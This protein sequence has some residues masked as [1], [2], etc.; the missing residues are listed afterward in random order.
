MKK[1]IRNFDFLESLKPGSNELKVK[2]IETLEHC[3]QLIVVI[4]M[5]NRETGHFKMDLH[6]VF[7][8]RDKK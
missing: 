3:D 2:L 5:L 4:N 6:G 1:R 7:R 8:G